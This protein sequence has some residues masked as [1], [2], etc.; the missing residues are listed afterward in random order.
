MHHFNDAEK[1]EELDNNTSYK[2]KEFQNKYDNLDKSLHKT[3]NKDTE[4]LLLNK[5]DMEKDIEKDIE[6]I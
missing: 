3:L 6:K 1:S 4:L 2:F 5:K